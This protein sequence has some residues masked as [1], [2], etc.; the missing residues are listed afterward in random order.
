MPYFLEYTSETMRRLRDSGLIMILSGYESNEENGLDY[1]LK[2]N[3]VE[4]NQKAAQI[5]MDLGIISTGIFMVRPDFEESDFDKLYAHIN[6][7]GVSIPL[8]TIL[9]PL[10]G[11]QLYKAREKEL[12]TKDMRLFDLLH[13][14]LPTK[15][16]IINQK[17]PELLMALR[18]DLQ[19]EVFD[20]VRTFKCDKWIIPLEGQTGKPSL[21]GA[22]ASLAM[23]M[24]ACMMLSC[25]AR[26]S[27]APTCTA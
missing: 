16:P 26:A 2:R 3:T 20:R 17:L 21:K 27:C 5:L 13:A 8:I 25:A 12:L 18:D 4:K 24:S 9:T 1:L 14:V 15:I 23:A 6:E 19:V 7:L 10:P 11:T 22:V